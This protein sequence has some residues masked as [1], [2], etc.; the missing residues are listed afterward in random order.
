MT[1]DQIA[2][3]IGFQN[4]HAMLSWQG[5]FLTTITKVRR[6]VAAAMAREREECAK[7]CEALQDGLDRHKWPNGY[8]C[9]AAIRERGNDV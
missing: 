9:A 2:E 4:G 6:L 7:V 8:D 1:D 3:A 5:P